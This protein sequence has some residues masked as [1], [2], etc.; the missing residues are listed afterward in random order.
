MYPVELYLKVRQ[1]CLTDGNSERQTAKDFGLSRNS[2]RKMLMYS[3]PPGYRR[4]VTISQPALD[5]YKGFIEEILESDKQ[6]HRKQRHTA[7]R[8]Y[9]RLQSE[10]GYTGSYSPVRKYIADYRLKTKEMYIPLEH[11][12]GTAQVDFG[13]SFAIIAGVHQKVNV[14]NMSLPQS[15]ACFVKAYPRENTESFCDGHVSAFSFIGGI[16]GDILY[17]NTKIAVA[18]IMGN[19]ERKKT[20]AFTEL[21]S[22]YLFKDHFARPGKGNDK[23]KVE[24][25]VGFARRNFMVPV[26]SFDS[27]EALNNHLQKCCEDRQKDTLRG[28]KTSIKERLVLDQKALSP[29]PERPYDPCVVSS[30][31][32]SSTSLVRYQETDY[33][34]PVR[35]GYQDVFVKAYIDKIL[36]IKGSE[37]I[38]THKRSYAKGDAVY[39]LLHYLPLLEQKANAL[40]QA[41]P[42]KAY[43]LPPIFDRFRTR[44]MTRDSVTANREYI[45]IL[46]LLE[47][48]GI[49]A[50]EKGLYLA[51][52]QG[53]FSVEAIKHL[54]LHSLEKRSSNLSLKDFPNV[55]LVC[56]QKTNMSSYMGLLGGAS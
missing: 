55:P 40:D 36:I 52:D 20:K 3:K 6:V 51:F 34:V 37:I 5:P 38:A 32:V 56:V 33:S 22:H 13:E 12:P 24:G 8:L 1:H 29:L 16:P 54:I 19:K 7:K 10:K 17:D 43:S 45:K 42:L 39:D 11:A 18:K 15:D 31:R 46:R 47:I 4:K 21:Q 2:V 50:V 27:F 30:A 25:V 23:G 53:I 41:A 14:F 48:H 9:D 44:L 26:P 28:H 35:Y 49:D